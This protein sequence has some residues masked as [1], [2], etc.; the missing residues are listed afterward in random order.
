MQWTF[1]MILLFVTELCWLSLQNGENLQMTYHIFMW[2]M[3]ARDFLYAFSL[4]QSLA[5]GCYRTMRLSNDL[6][7]FQMGNVCNGHFV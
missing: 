3:F 2:G 7:N 5:V 4:C 1:F 6:C